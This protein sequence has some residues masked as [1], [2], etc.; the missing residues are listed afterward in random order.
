MIILWTT[1]IGV[2]AHL[3]VINVLATGELVLWR[4]CMP[5]ER[6]CQS[7]FVGFMPQQVTIQPGDGVQFLSMDSANA[8]RIVCNDTN[9]PY[10]FESNPLTSSGGYYQIGVVTALGVFPFYDLNFPT[11]TGSFTV[12]PLNPQV[13]I[14]NVSANCAYPAATT[15]YVGDTLAI[16]NTDTNSVQYR[17]YANY[18]ST[19]SADLAA[20]GAIAAAGVA[21]VNTTAEADYFQGTQI[22]LTCVLCACCASLLTMSSC[23]VW[24]NQADSIILSVVHQHLLHPIHQDY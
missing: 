24:E 15:I 9:A 13:V 18:P 5:A 19:A 4:R 21:Y 7:H 12:A 1:L 6:F 16:H 14:V 2:E 8:H 17:V 23:G 22:I 20:Y 10:N 11:H 3:F